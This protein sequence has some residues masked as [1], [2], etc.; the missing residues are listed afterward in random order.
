MRLAILDGGQVVFGVLRKR[1]CDVCGQPFETYSANQKRCTP[2]CS[3]AAR[4]VLM[5]QWKDKQKEKK[6]KC[7]HS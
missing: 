6:A 1:I 4:M 2:K 3:H 5:R 7:A